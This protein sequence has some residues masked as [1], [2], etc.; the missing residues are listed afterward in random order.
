MKL[1]EANHPY[2]C[3]DGNYR[4]APADGG[5]IVR[6][7]SWADFFAK[8]GDSDPDQ[9]LVFRWDWTKPDPDDYVGGEDGDFYPGE[10]LD[11][12]V[13]QQRHGDFWVWSIDVHPE[14]EPEIRAWLTGRART[15]AAIWAPIPLEATPWNR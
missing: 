11:L 6:F 9:N 1:W 8:N 12:Y 2:Y 13:M 15:L 5:N 10:T 7:D 4:V 14:D 3:H